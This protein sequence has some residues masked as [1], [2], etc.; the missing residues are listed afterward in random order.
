MQ[1]HKSRVSELEQ[2]L[3]QQSTQSNQESYR[4]KERITEL[5]HIVTINNNKF[6]AELLNY[7]DRV[8]ELE[9]S[10]RQ[11]TAHAEQAAKKVEFNFAQERT[12]L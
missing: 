12:H 4:Y 8:S 9:N 3:R 10:L 2:K 1:K 11:Q 7:Q 5:E 6:N